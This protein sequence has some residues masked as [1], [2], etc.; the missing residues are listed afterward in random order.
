[1]GD[2]QFLCPHCHKRLVVARE[3]AGRQVACPGC[4][5]KIIIPKSAGL[6][7]PVSINHPDDIAVHQVRTFQDNNL[8]HCEGHVQNV[9]PEPHSFVQ[10]SV[11][12]LDET[13]ELLHSDWTF[14]VG[15]EGLAP[16]QQTSF[17]FDAPLHPA[18]KRC[19]LTI[20]I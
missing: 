19:R 9:G 15:G 7:L 13:D 12:W 17:Q 5:N 20:S 3:G 4:E 8:L 16:E 1:M 18:V 10:V 6:R 14:A 2:I 11:A